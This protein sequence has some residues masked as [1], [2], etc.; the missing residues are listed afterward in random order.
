VSGNDMPIVSGPDVDP[1]DVA[2]AAQ[3]ARTVASTA[4]AQQRTRWGWS[5]I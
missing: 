4:T 5:L 3:P 2:V 1:L